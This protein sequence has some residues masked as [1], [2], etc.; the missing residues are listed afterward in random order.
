[1][2]EENSMITY[3]NLYDILRKEKHNTEL[4]EIDEN[5]YNKILKY[6]EEK[7]EILV[8]QSKN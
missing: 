7:K 3:E 1:M 8:S 4:Q 2:T 5:F 6:I